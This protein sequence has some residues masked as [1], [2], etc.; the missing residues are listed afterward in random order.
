[1]SDAPSAAPAE[2]P[3]DT[4]VKKKASRK[5]IIATAAIAYLL[6]GLAGGYIGATRFAPDASESVTEDNAKNEG[7]AEIRGHGDANVIKVS[8]IA[9]TLRPDMTGEKRS[10]LVTP[11]L[12]V[13]PDGSDE[14]PL[15]S[16][17]SSEDVLSSK[18]PVLRDIFIE[19]LSQLEPR[20]VA[21]SAGMS[22][23]RAELKRRAEAVLD[24]Y[25]V[26]QVLFNDYVIQ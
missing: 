1:M 3:A 26:D 23:V 4:P 8:R 10:F 5:V 17:G 12:T 18:V 6:G 21:G 15:D 7:D 11:I 16:H 24:D 25:K 14:A 22:R 20:E 19:Y 9:L 13:Q 2:M